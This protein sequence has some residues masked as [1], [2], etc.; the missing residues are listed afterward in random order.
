MT[1]NVGGVLITDGNERAALAVT[2]SLGYHGIQVFV[3]A[4]GPRSLAGSSRFCTQSFEYPSPWQ[5]PEAYV[6]C[7][8]EKARMWGVAAIFPMTDIAMELFGERDHAFDQSIAMPIPQLEQYHRL[9]DKYHLTSW[10]HTNGIPIPPTLF[11]PDGRID[12]AIEN[13]HSWPVVIKPGRSLLKHR[14]IWR[15]SAVNIA[16]DADELRRFYHEAWFLQQPS[17]IQQYI[18]GHGEGVF[19]I[20]ENGKPHTLFAHRRLRERPP[21]GGVSVLREAIALPDPMTGYATHIMRDARWNGIAMVEFRI[22]E[23]SGTPFLMEVNGRFWGSLQLAVDAGV[24]FPMML[25]NQATSQVSRAD[26]AYCVGIRSQWWL[27]DLDHLL[28]RLRTIGGSENAVPKE[29]PSRWNTFFGLINIFDKSTR[30]E[31]LRLSDISPGLLEL[32]AYAAYRFTAIA[33]KVGYRIRQWSRVMRYGI[34]DF[35]LSHDFHRKSLTAR[36]PQGPKRILVLCKGNICRSPF[37]EIYLRRAAEHHKLQI[38]ISSAGMEAETGIAA[39]PLAKS[40]APLFGVDL[41]THRTTSMADALVEEADIILVME[42]DHVSQL[43][44]RFPTTVKRTFLLGWFIQERPMTEIKDP[45]GGSHD[46]FTDCY[47]TLVDACDGFMLYLRRILPS[48][49]EHT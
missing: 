36:L 15:K 34:I 23:Q 41:D 42:P 25:Y 29:A 24:D 44:E 28:A 49:I 35:G 43:A 4:E 39:Y 37:V 30:N 47:T 1:N 27:G 16:S 38:S 31:V 3:G 21:S 9:S 33:K 20:F 46:T 6:A 8:I 26:D 45:Y 12:D 48:S 18:S 11:I 17:M 22:D 19:G 5:E 7:L 32:R 40:V 2:R 13:L 10:A 14:G